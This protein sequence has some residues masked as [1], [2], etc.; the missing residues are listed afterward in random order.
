MLEAIWIF[1][2]IQFRRYNS[3]VNLLELQI[4]RPEKCSML[5]PFLFAFKSLERQP[6]DPGELNQIT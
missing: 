6:S 3:A 5:E 2:K 1:P 4:Q